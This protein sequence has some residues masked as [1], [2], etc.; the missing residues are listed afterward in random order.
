MSGRAGPLNATARHIIVGDVHGNGRGVEQLLDLAS[1]DPSGDILIFV[2]DYN[3]HEPDLGC[4]VSRLIEQLMRL[5]AAAPGRVIFVRGNHDMWFAQW[6]EQ[7]GDPP[8]SWMIQ[9]GRETLESYGIS[10]VYASRNLRDKVPLSHQD[11]F[12]HQIDPYYLDDQVI[13]VHGGFT[14]ERQ[15][16]MIA[17]GGQLDKGDLEELIWDRQFIFAEDESSHILYR[18]YFENRYLVT[19]HSPRGP[20][21][22]PR[23]DKWILIDSPL[24]G[25]QL[26]AAIIQGDRR[27]ELISTTVPQ[28]LRAAS[29]LG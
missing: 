19:G 26:C 14:T 23:N 6:L 24:K 3:D 27:L 2:G 13:V 9:G 20:Y 18:Q 21:V 8:G 17:G 16:G 1:Y 15:M 4:S 25:Q 10:D 28:T 11:F 22:N 5:R 7:G 29:F 12:S